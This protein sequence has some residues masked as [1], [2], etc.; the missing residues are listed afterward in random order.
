MFRLHLQPIISVFVAVSIFSFLAREAT[1]TQIKTNSQ[2]NIIAIEDLNI[3]DS[4][5]QVNFSY[6]TFNHLFGNPINPTLE[7]T[8]WLDSASASA[9]RDAIDEVL[10][11]LYPAVLASG[12]GQSP[13]DYLIPQKSALGLLI[14]DES[15]N[16]SQSPHIF[17]ALWGN[18]RNYY[19]E[20]QW[21]ESLEALYA[22]GGICSCDRMLT[23]N[24][25]TFWGTDVNTTRL[26]AIFTPIEAQSIP[27]PLTLLDTATALGFGTIFK[28]KLK[29]K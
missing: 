15:G 14:I 28:R 17:G 8:F 13:L 16:V 12:D 4:V 18:Y 23:I 3:E 29:Q 19:G 6:S 2:G 26:F 25:E 20:R 27:E 10:K 7:P 24:S 21:N 22:S 1:A 5:Y 11:S 9:A